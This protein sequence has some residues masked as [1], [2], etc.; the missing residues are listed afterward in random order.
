[1]A[2]L[3]QYNILTR[4]HDIFKYHRLSFLLEIFFIYFTCTTLHNQ[5][6]LLRKHPTKRQNFK[7]VVREGKRPPFPPSVPPFLH[8]AI[9]LTKPPCFGAQLQILVAYPP[10]TSIIDMVKRE[11]DM[12]KSRLP[13]FLTFSLY[14]TNC[15]I[16]V[17]PPPPR[18]GPQTGIYKEKSRPPF[19]PQFGQKRGLHGKKSPPFFPHFPSLS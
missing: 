19:F 3:H 1:M 9:M 17:Q 14:L 6:I 7:E 10:D 2:A 16:C 11:I 13:F 18:F 8:F 15:P 12:E 5:L 4:M